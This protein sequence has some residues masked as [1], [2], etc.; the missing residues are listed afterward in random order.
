MESVRA[1]SPALALI[2]LSNAAN[3][4]SATLHPGAHRCLSEL[5]G[6]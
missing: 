1:S 3:G 4:L 5:G 2:S 6:L